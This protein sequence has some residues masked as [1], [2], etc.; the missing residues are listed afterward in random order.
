MLLVANVPYVKQEDC[1]SPAAYNGKIADTMICAGEKDGGVDSCQGDSG[2][3][4]V[5]RESTG[6]V[7]VGVVAFG[8][9][10]ARKLKYGIYTRVSRYRDWI[11]GT[12]K[13][14]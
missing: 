4:L 6:P 7:L 9:G 10:C 5:S 2:G 11:R 8:D 1:N 12:I 14:N 13:N 3:P